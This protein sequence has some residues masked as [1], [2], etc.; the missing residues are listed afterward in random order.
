[1]NVTEEPEHPGLVPVVNTI[2]TV[3]ATEELI[4]IVIPE[5][6]AVVGLAQEELEVITHVT[7]C[8]LVRADDV[9]VGEF[10]PAFV[11]FTFH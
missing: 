10:V 1:M 7:I 3:G 11:P 9:N 4:D 5:L 2:A 8:P 6:V